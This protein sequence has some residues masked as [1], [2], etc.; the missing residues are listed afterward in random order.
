VLEVYDHMGALVHHLARRVKLLTN[1][2]PHVLG[3][4]EEMVHDLQLPILVYR[5]D[6]TTTKKVILT[7]H[8]CKLM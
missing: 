1:V 6:C 4:T 7:L 8:L 2:V 5:R 3:L